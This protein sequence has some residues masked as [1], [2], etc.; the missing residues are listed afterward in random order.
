[1]NQPF[2]NNL[3]SKTQA[4]VHKQPAHEKKKNLLYLICVAAV[5]SLLFIGFYL[6]HQNFMNYMAL[7]SKKTFHQIILQQKFNVNSA[8][9]SKIIALENMGSSFAYIQDNQSAVLELLTHVENN[10]EFDCLA[11][12]GVNGKGLM[13]NGKPL[14]ISADDYYARVITGE[15]VVSAPIVI[16]G[17]DTKVIP[18]A[19]PI[20]RNDEMTGILVGFLTPQSLERLILSAFDGKVYCYVIDE[21]GNVMF[22]ARNAY[23]LS[24]QPN[25]FELWKSLKF[26]PGY[27]FDQVLQNIVS[28]TPGTVS[29][30][31]DSQF[32][33]AEY[34]P[35]EVN[36]W[37]IIL[38]VPLN[39]IVP[40]TLSI[41]QSTSMLIVLV[42]LCFALLVFYIL[43]QQNHNTRALEKLAFYDD[44]S[45]APTLAKF[46]LE[47]SKFIA[48]TTN[49]K[50]LMVKF[51]IAQF[52]LINQILGDSVGDA[53]IRALVKALDMNTPGKY[54]RYARLH[55]DEFLVLHVY[56]QVEELLEIRDRF[57]KYIYDLMGSTFQYNL[58]LVSGHYYMSDEKCTDVTEAIEKANIA[59][60]KAKQTGQEICI[61]DQSM[62][63]E[64]LKQ[65]AVEL[66]MR[67][68]LLNNE[69]KVYLQS[70]YELKTATIVGAEALVRWVTTEGDI[71]YPNDFIPIFEH[72]GFIIELDF[73]MFEHACSIIRGWLDHGYIPVPISVNFSRLHTFNTDFVHFLCGLADQYQVSHH[74][75]E[76]ELTESIMFN[77]EDALQ[78]VLVELHDHGF[79]L[80]M[81]DF[82]VGY[83]S[84]GL[85]KNLP[86]DVLKID[87][88]FFTNDKDEVRAKLII[89]SI[90]HLAKKLGIHTVAEGVEIKEHIDLL[91]E[92][93]CDIVQGY[94]FSRPVPADEF[95]DR[96]LQSANLS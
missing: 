38:A 59:H 10:S 57:Q 33:Y 4:K 8:V 90:M 44:F 52:K 45:G 49:K 29:Y 31:S 32:R 34:M 74:L 69:F 77:N 95:F 47:A 82:G 27:S 11:I 51:D 23:T 92:V 7:T 39:M 50:L 3:P 30:G 6:Y 65:K 42:I 28:K 60:R 93:G 21:Q 2:K 1:M 84:L 91:R 70:K 66:K 87:R 89:E 63:D 13:S 64:S 79:L 94:Y 67:P 56:E 46:K 40:D 26:D 18:L 83:S 14:D 81:D 22:N 85:L 9:N 96:Q 61:Y 72:N 5:F 36:D 54:K 24:N 16:P 68:A 75:L 48:E 80:S 78:A 62:I 43:Y 73:Y 76:I 12:T 58:K 88:S 53:A 41:T 20:S 25:V 15:T 35:L 71:T 55:D 37:S 19:T 17:T 86:V